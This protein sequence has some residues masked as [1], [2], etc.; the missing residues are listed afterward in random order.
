MPKLR[1]DF[2]LFRRNGQ[3]PESHPFF[4]A[5]FFKELRPGKRRGY[6]RAEKTS[7][8]SVCMT[9]VPAKTFEE[10]DAKTGGAVYLV[11]AGRGRGLLKAKTSV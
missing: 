4:H 9:V 10:N 8:A 7:L 3:A 1:G 5:A 2:D 11:M 6:C